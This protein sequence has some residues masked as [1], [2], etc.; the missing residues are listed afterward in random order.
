MA[1]KERLINKG[2]FAGTAPPGPSAASR[3][4]CRSDS[5]L[6]LGPLPM[7]DIELAFMMYVNRAIV[8]SRLWPV[9]RGTGRSTR[10]DHNDLSVAGPST[11][12]RS[13]P[14]RWCTAGIRVAE[15]AHPG[16]ALP[17][18]VMI[19]RQRCRDIPERSQR[20]VLPPP[21]RVVVVARI[22]AYLRHLGSFD[23][24]A[25][26]RRQPVEYLKLLALQFDDVRAIAGA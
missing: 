6:D 16:V 1:T 15:R 7:C 21:R 11:W 3:Q 14:S 10:D 4:S 18:G 24:V 20:Y 13:D 5:G 17:S 25:A 2:D 26:D 8:V 9:A 22:A 23:D 12:A 19:P